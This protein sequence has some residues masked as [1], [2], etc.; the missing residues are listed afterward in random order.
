M[1]IT[2]TGEAKMSGETIEAAM[3]DSEKRSS[4]YSTVSDPYNDDD[5]CELCDS[6]VDYT[7]DKVHGRCNC[8][9]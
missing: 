3:W 4:P 9:G 8:E 5:F 1:E 2:S 6:P 7:V